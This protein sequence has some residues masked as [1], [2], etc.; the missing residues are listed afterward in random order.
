M[1]LTAYGENRA[2]VTACGWLRAWKDA[3]VAS[4]ET[5]YCGAR[6]NELRT[7]TK[8]WVKVAC[9]LVAIGALELRSIK[10]CVRQW[11]ASL[12]WLV[13]SGATFGPLFADWNRTASG[14]SRVTWTNWPCSY[15]YCPHPY[16]G[17]QPQP[18]L[19]L[20]LF[21]AINQRGGDLKKPTVA[22]LFRN[23]PNFMERNYSLLYSQKPRICLALSQIN[24]VH[25]HPIPLPS[26]L[27][28]SSPTTSL[29]SKRSL[30]L[31]LS[32]Q[33]PVCIFSHTYMLHAPPV[34]CS[35]ILSSE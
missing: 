21:T 34:S 13:Q 4:E 10:T 14:A 30:S 32:Y 20:R 33:N 27:V 6:L 22:Q 3:A 19:L 18:S 16:G 17:P 9:L 25:T 31:R 24:P 26:I 35:L 1:Q 11:A 7:T 15:V 5:H 2:D 12:G 23:V 28:L 8:T 29:Y